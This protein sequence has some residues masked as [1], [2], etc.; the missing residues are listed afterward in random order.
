MNVEDSSTEGRDKRRP[1]HDAPHSIT[2]AGRIAGIPSTENVMTK[3]DNVSPYIAAELQRL[4]P[5]G[6][7][8]HS[9]LTAWEK[10]R[11]SMRDV[12]VAA[13]KTRR[14]VQRT[15]RPHRVK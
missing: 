14:R 1:S 8:P 9:T 5:D 4:Y 2:A 7:Y 10:M 6:V 11:V 13:L 3:T 15:L 12:I